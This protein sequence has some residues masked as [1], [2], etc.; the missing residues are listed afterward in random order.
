MSKLGIALTGVAV[1]LLAAAG[2]SAWLIA[3]RPLRVFAWAMRRTLKRLGLVQIAI[4]SPSGP[5]NAFLGGNGPLLVLIHGAGDHAGT[6]A[7]VAPALLKDHTLLIPDLAGHGQS[8]PAA[9][10]IDTAVIVA[11]L[12]AVLEN[13]CQGRKATLVG[14]SL[15]AWMAM[16]MAQRLPGLVE[17]V[18][19]VNGGSLP[20]SG[21]P[22]NLLPT[23]RQEARE[24]MAQLRDPSNPPVPDTVLDDMIRQ[25]RTSSLARFAGTFATMAPWLMT[26]DQLRTLQVPVRM[27]WGTADALMPLEYAARMQAVLPDSRL[28]PVERCGHV[29]QSEAPRRFLDALAKALEA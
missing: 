17:K 2:L 24:T 15:G 7:K 10:P 21:K 18:V 25:A 11:G 27:V 29:P 19:A 14:N 20:G 1:L 6:W 4:P 12:E 13:A 3:K 28:F 5:Q 9:G 23:T 16:V 22:V 26:E 8:A